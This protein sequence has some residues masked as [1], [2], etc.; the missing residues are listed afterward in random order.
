MA[1]LETG[2]LLLLRLFLYT[3]TIS[4]SLDLNPKLDFA[5][6]STLFFFVIDQLH[7][8]RIERDGGGR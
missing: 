5:I 4:L 1:T 3:F 2:L 7:L 8:L 6:N